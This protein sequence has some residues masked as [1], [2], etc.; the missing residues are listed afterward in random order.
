MDGSLWALD[1][2]IFVN[3]VLR[4][5]TV[6]KDILRVLRKIELLKSLNTVQLQRLVDLMSEVQYETGNTII[7]QGD[8]GET[9]YVIVSGTCSVTIEDASGEVKE[10]AKLGSHSFFGERALLT[11]E[12]RAAT[13]TALTDVSLLQV[14]SFFSSL[15]FSLL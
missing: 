2:F 1:R 12:P 7:K 9:F 10:V 13:I 5:Q 11:S 3:S 8:P 14:L 6:R 4:T 15:L